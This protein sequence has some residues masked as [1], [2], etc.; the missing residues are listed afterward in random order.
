MN[1]RLHKVRQHFDAPRLDDVAAHTAAQLRENAPAIAPGARIGVAVG[2]R[3]IANLSAIVTEVVAYLKSQGVKPFIFPAMGSHGGATAEGQRDVLASL[4]ITEAGVGAPVRATM[5]TVEVDA[6]D[7]PAKVYMD[8]FAWEA[9][10]I[11]LVNRIK[12]HTDFHSTY[13]SGL[14]KMCV[15]GVGKHTGALEIHRFGLK[16]LKDILPRVATRI[17]ATGKAVM[18]V[19]ILENA[20]DE[21]MD[22]RVMPGDEIL[23]IEPRLLEL[24][25]AN[26]PRLPVDDV[27]ILIVD[28]LGKDISGT[29]MDTNVI[30]RLGILGQADPATPN[31]R[32]ILLDDITPGSHGNAIGI[33]LAD[34]VT[35]KLVHKI[36]HEA[37]YENVRTSTFLDR[38]KIPFT[39]PDAEAGFAVAQRV[40]GSTPP[41]QLRVLRIKNTL[42]VGNLYVSR[43][44]LPELDNVDVLAEASPLFT[45]E[46]ELSPFD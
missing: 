25:T 41:D 8:R 27:D 15:L 4:G 32:C 30:G 38:A 17:L 21:T 16:G 36:D 35:Q 11:V 40:C 42:K 39:A 2:S 46:G 13:E 31:V 22:L 45:A 7:C 34:I 18:G 37:L 10:G 5:D 26:M 24:A 43:A 9:D 6:G 33:G 19:A 23:A 3:G 1:L 12:P 28:E 14:V 29:G 44:L 20:Y